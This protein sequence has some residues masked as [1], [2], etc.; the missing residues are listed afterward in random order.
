MG[1]SLKRI[2]D[3]VVA[4]TLQG[5]EHLFL[6]IGNAFQEVP[7]PVLAAAIT[8]TIGFPKSADDLSAEFAA[9]LEEDAD[10]TA[11]EF[12]FSLPAGSYILS[13]PDDD[14]VI[15]YQ[16]TTLE[17]KRG[18]VSRWLFTSGEKST[19]A[20]YSTAYDESDP[21][22]LI[23]GDSGE[24]SLQGETIATRTDITNAMRGLGVP[25]V[26]ESAASAE[27]AQNTYAASGDNFPT[28]V[29]ADQTPDHRPVGKGSQIV[30]IPEHNNTG[31]DP[32]LTLNNGVSV[33]IRQRA[34]IDTQTA[35]NTVQ[36]AK[37]TLIQGMPYTLTFCGVAWLIDSYLPGEG[38]E[39]TAKVTS[40]NGKT[41]RV[42]ITADG[43]G[44]ALASYNWQNAK[45]GYDIYNENVEEITP[46]DYC[47]EILP[48]GLYY[49]RAD[50]GQHFMIRSD[51]GSMIE[52]V[53][54]EEGEEG[55]PAHRSGPA[56]RAYLFIPTE[57]DNESTISGGVWMGES[58]LIEINSLE[59]LSSLTF[60]VNDSKLVTEA[61]L[62]QRLT[63]YVTHASLLLT[64]AQYAKILNPTF[65]GCITIEP[66]PNANAATT[67][68]I[69][70]N[71]VKMY[72]G[73]ASVTLTS[74]FTNQNNIMHLLGT[75][76]SGDIIVR[77]VKNPLL[78]N[79]A[80]NKAYVDAVFMAA[81]DGRLVRA[82]YD[83]T[84]YSDI[85]E[86]FNAGKLI[87]LS[88]QNS[89]LFC[90]ACGQGT[91]YFSSASTDYFVE[92]GVQGN[93][94]QT[95]WS[96]IGDGYVER[97]DNKVNSLT[98]AVTHNQYPS[99]KATYDAIKALRDLTSWKDITE[100]WNDYREDHDELDFVSA[101]RSFTKTLEDGR[102]TFSGEGSV[103]HT[104]LITAGSGGN[105]AQYRFIWF[106]LPDGNVPTFEYF[107]G[108]TR[109]LG[110]SSPDGVLRLTV[111]GKTV[112]YKDDFLSALAGLPT[113]ESVLADV[114]T[115]IN[116]VTQTY[117]ALS[118]I[119]TRLQKFKG[120]PHTIRVEIENAQMLLDEEDVI[121]QLWVCS[122]KHGTAHHWWHPGQ[123]GSPTKSSPIG[124]A[125]IA[126]DLIY[127]NRPL[128]TSRFPVVPIWMPNN[129]YMLTEVPVT[130]QDLVNGYVDID[131]STYFLP[132][133]KPRSTTWKYKDVVMMFTQRSTNPFKRYS[134]PV[135]W[136]VGVLRD[137]VYQTVGSSDNIA[138]IGFRRN[139]TGTLVDGTTK[140]KTIKS[141]HISIE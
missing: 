16:C 128:T 49:L 30:F 42:S 28:V 120:T 52:A 67:T 43:I 8:R 1:I 110:T 88:Y 69:Y 65:N 108:D 44:A 131:C 27:L 15:T 80:A 123:P 71:K 102:Y 104:H 63:N 5:D 55:T 83:V 135:T 34:A 101:A 87:Y 60:L 12:L 61:M 77:G 59:D 121:L 106:V 141:L 116:A 82:E 14:D 68:K 41:G 133:I 81:A 94:S 114:T 79:D 21:L 78:N 33:P 109:I 137:G 124:Y 37:D 48:Q 138:K 2:T 4:Q 112:V 38:S 115:K 3:M 96:V 130:H 140:K 39:T 22:I 7:L 105:T 10:L 117:N 19:A 53:E 129:G 118:V 47:F 99:A 119:R 90:Y 50:D 74:S 31:T 36:I 32:M 136:K 89:L 103:V 26:K 57:V 17:G 73:S 122:R 93:E 125:M 6:Q 66:A 111:L 98:A 132:F 84:S 56:V 18:N 29:P 134:V 24:L 100:E 40:V 13:V 72:S 45:R 85:E 95:N 23:D 75:N 113:R 20:L 97:K 35:D 64:L 54:G 11:Q 76:E 46:S 86:A 70:P 126:G 91:A 139:D 58:K 107:K 9:A 51:M 25:I 127:P 92:V 62:L